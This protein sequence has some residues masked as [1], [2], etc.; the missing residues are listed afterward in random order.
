[1][2][3]RD[4]GVI[5]DQNLKINGK[6][7][8]KI[9]HALKV[10]VEI[11]FTINNHIINL[12]SSFLP[13]L[14]QFKLFF[15]GWIFFPFFFSFF[16][17]CYEIEEFQRIVDQSNSDSA[18]K[19]YKKLKFCCKIRSLSIT[20]SILSKSIQFTTSTTVQMTEKYRFFS[21]FFLLVFLL[22]YERLLISDRDW[23]SK[24]NEIWIHS[25]KFWKNNFL[26]YLKVVSW[27]ESWA[28]FKYVVRTV[29]HCTYQKFQINLLRCL[30]I[31][32]IL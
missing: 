31:G 3:L 10:I 14:K 16:Q 20:H 21:T 9:H 27:T 5:L 4:T 24:W 8:L 26:L 30:L 23:G 13:L 2:Q 29:I 25:N 11:V 19:S 15:F 7:I 12:K 32:E 1:M 22:F 6:I 18:S 28:L 17:F